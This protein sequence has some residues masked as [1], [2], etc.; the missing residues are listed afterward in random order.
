MLSQ[1]NGNTSKKECLV[2][3]MEIV[4]NKIATN[5]R[6]EYCS[7]LHVRCGLIEEKVHRIWSNHELC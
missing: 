4:V 7:G 3:I 6:S 2:K 1:D 5:S